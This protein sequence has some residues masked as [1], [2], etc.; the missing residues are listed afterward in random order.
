MTKIIKYFINNTSLNH[1]L[2]IV[3][4]MAGVLAYIKIPKEIFPDV[5]LNKIL[6]AGAY[7]G[8]S[9]TIL[10]KM[11]VRDIEDDLSSV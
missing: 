6:V 9:A 3:L 8:A 1:M 2:L 11:V 7:S 4:L 5:T 10:D